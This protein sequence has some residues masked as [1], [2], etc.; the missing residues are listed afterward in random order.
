MT[1]DI[2]R[3]FHGLTSYRCPGSPAQLES[4]TPSQCLLREVP[5]TT[6]APPPVKRYPAG[7][8]ITPL[9]RALPFVSMSA[10]AALAGVAPDGPSQFDLGGLARLLYLSAGVVRVTERDGQQV[11]FRA[12]G[13]AGARFPLE[14]YVAARDLPGVPDG[15]HWYDPV[16]HAL[17]Q[18]GPAPDRGTWAVIIT[19]VP[20]RTGWRY[21]ERGYRHLYWDAGVLLAHQLALAASADVPAR[22]YSRFPDASVGALVGAD[23]VHEFALAVIALG[24]G[25]PPVVPSGPAASGQIAWDPVEFP[26]ITA[27]QRAGDTGQLGVPWPDADPLT[28]I[29]P[30]SAPLDEVILRR[31]ST[32]L[33]DPA[34]QVPAPA[35]T[36]SLAAAS[37]GVQNLHYVAVHGVGG[38]VPGL[39]AWPELN[40]PAR[41][42]NLRADVRRICLSQDLAGDA[43]YVVIAAANLDL[44]DARSYRC[45]QLAAGLTAGRLHL[46]AFAQGFGASGMTFFDSEISQFLEAPVVGLL[47]TCVGVPEYQSRAGGR[48]GHPVHVRPPAPRQTYCDS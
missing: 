37:R 6:P 7:L 28:G 10:T 19:G 26:L 1:A 27:M 33:M 32:R 41:T 14:V 38:K 5:A 11:L 21:A 15:I 39:Y 35:L 48:P 40:R 3:M 12:A 42:G 13:S 4:A 29:P 47:C 17:H 43:A 24:E 18:I 46:A 25:E 9:P 45:A 36:W 23:G 2:M 8:R 22:V 30:A 44:L 16:A 31:G 20:W 34:S